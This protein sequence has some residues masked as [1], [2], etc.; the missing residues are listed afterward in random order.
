M[1]NARAETLAQKLA[2]RG[3]LRNRRCLVLAAGLYEWATEPGSRR[4]LPVHV[5]L[6]SGKPLALAGLWDV[7]RAP[8]GACLRSFTITTTDANERLAP[9]HVRM[10]VTL[11]LAGCSA[12]CCERLAFSAVFTTAACP[13]PQW[14]RPAARWKRVHR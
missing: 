5:T 13:R 4:K 1:I 12:P 3:P 10:P 8:D 6:A 9:I 14:A 7:W 11:P 2:V